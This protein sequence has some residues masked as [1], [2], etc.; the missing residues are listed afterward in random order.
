[1]ETDFLCSIN[2]YICQLISLCEDRL[3]KYIWVFDI[4]RKQWSWG[5]VIFSQ[6][7]VIL[8]TGVGGL[9]QCM[10]GYHPPARQTPSGKADA[11]RQGDPS[12]K[13]DPP[14]KETL[15]LGRPPLAR[16]PPAA[17]CMLGDMVNK[18]AVCILLECNSCCN[19]SVDNQ[20]E[21]KRNTNLRMHLLHSLNLCE[22]PQSVQNIGFLISVSWQLWIYSPLLRCL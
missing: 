17:Q 15:Q 7:S 21:K 20:D 18:Q 12:G 9:P 19:C 5:E 10:L 16:R 22:M 4:Y 8:F 11:P 6:A 2:F 13:A 3:T 14:G 1:M